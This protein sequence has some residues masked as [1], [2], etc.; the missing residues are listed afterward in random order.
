MTC[1]P[2]LE[3]WDLGHKLFK[4]TPDTFPVTFVPGNVFDPEHLSIV[5]LF[6][7]NSPPVTT[8][9]DLRTLTSLNPL[10][11]HV[12]AICA[13]ALFHLF[14]KDEQLRVARALAGLLSP[15]PGSMILG[16]QVG[17]PESE[18]CEV[19]ETPE[20][21]F[22]QR[23]HTSQSWLELWDGEVFPKGTVRALAFV[24]EVPED[25][26]AKILPEAKSLHML[27]WS[28]TRL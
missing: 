4:T 12:S 8:A 18:H 16:K 25:M 14:P 5:P 9:P 11:G 2:P 26:V 22:R 17:L 1:I 27:T 19:S 15:K 3:F 21:T 10:R 28:V 13:S 20:S 6:T 23:C 7:A 24:T